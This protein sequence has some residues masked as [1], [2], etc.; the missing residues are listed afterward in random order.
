MNEHDRKLAEALLTDDAELIQESGKGGS[1]I[2]DVLETLHGSRGALNILVWVFATVFA[3]LMFWGGYRFF[4]ED[5][6]GA[7]LTWGMLCLFGI[8]ANGMLKLWAWMEIN[9]VHAQRD[10]RRIELR[11]AVLDDRLRGGRDGDGG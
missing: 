6:I 10:L 3:V 4:T 8:I 11:L 5:E 2:R 9:R 7:R 1:I